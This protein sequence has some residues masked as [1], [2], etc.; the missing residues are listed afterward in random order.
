[1]AM[2]A[3]N[4]KHRVCFDE[5][6]Y[7]EGGLRVGWN[8]GAFECWAAIRYLRGGETVQA[9]RLSGRQPAVITVRLPSE[10]ENVTTDW[11]LQDLN[12]NREYA[13]T[14]P[15]VPTD[16]GKWLEITCESGVA[17]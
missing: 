16:D 9:A 15:P 17:A 14:A 13:V 7:D 8:K 5:P 12:R 10:A 2:R 6:T 4:L 11:K 1:M 3:G